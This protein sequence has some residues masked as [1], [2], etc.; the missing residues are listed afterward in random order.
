M[1]TF[2]SFAPIYYTCFFYGLLGPWTKNPSSGLRILSH[3]IFLANISVLLWFIITSNSN[4][5]TKS[6]SAYLNYIIVVA[7]SVADVLVQIVCYLC[8]NKI[9]DI[10]LS[11]EEI[12][13]LLLEA[14]IQINHSIIRWLN[15]GIIC[16][17][18]ACN[19][20]QIGTFF[21]MQPWSLIWNAQVLYRL[22]YK[23][24]YHQ[25]LTILVSALVTSIL[26]RMV[27]LNA[28][29]A[30]I[31]NRQFLAGNPHS[32]FMCLAGVIKRCTKSTIYKYGR[33]HS[34]L[35]RLL[36]VIGG[37]FGTPIICFVI[38]YVGVLLLIMYQRFDE[39]MTLE[40]RK[41]KLVMEWMPMLKTIV[42]FALMATVCTR[43]RAEVSRGAV[44]KR[45]K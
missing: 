39:S 5:P 12:D 6:V 24:F 42:F 2:K 22:I 35:C 36:P 25:M 9:R 29:I 26:W 41:K 45:H 11:L 21:S 18:Q 33:I 14:N 1:T 43:L 28:G 34:K 32:R 44:R 37:V 19:V 38:I 30:M 16:L 13:H 27:A 23:Q 15:S 40:G 10:L 4:V 8:R 20:M 17:V 31:C 7:Y 3:F